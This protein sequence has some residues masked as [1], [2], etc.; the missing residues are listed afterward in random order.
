MFVLNRQVQ[1]DN[2][3][4]NV[5]VVLITFRATNRSLN[6]SNNSIG[7]V[8]SYTTICGTLFSICHTSYSRGLEHR[9]SMLKAMAVEGAGHISKFVLRPHTTPLTGYG[10][11]DSYLVEHLCWSETKNCANNKTT[12]SITTTSPV[13]RELVFIWNEKTDMQRRE[14]R[15]Q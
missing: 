2:R 9:G 15:S 13:K 10:N 5:L 6:K 12:Q 3:H 8:H 14:W 7:W 1:F 4:I 11:F